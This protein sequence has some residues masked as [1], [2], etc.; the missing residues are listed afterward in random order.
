[1]RHSTRLRGFIAGGV[2]TVGVISLVVGMYVH[3]LKERRLWALFVGPYE[4]V[5]EREQRFW[6]RCV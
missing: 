5:E 1:M 6:P 4:V 2:L 3:R